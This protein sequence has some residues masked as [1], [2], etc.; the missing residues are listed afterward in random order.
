MIWS[1]DPVLGDLLLTQEHRPGVATRS[2]HARPGGIRLP[3][4]APHRRE[5]DMGVKR[6]MGQYE[7]TFPPDD[8]RTLA[9]LAELTP[10][11]MSAG[12]TASGGTVARVAVLSAAVDPDPERTVDDIV[13]VPVVDVDGDGQQDVPGWP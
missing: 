8:P 3:G 13:P 12:V 11:A 9:E 6:I 5:A 2:L 7:V 4:R 1:L 10:V